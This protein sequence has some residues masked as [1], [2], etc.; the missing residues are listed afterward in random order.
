MFAEKG[1]MSK[2]RGDMCIYT[3]ADR[4]KTNQWAYDDAVQVQGESLF[5]ELDYRLLGKDCCE[6]RY[7]GVRAMGKTIEVERVYFGDR[8]DMLRWGKKEGKLPLIWKVISN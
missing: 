1:I 7:Q 4:I 6:V 8:M 2:A 5:L 3:D